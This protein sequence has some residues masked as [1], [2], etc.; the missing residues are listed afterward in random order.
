M[1]YV[2]DLINKINNM[3]TALEG[4]SW[5]Q[6]KETLFL[7]YNALGTAIANYATPVW[8]TSASD[9]SFK[10][11][12]TTQNAALTTATGDHKIFSIDHLHQESNTLKVRDHSDMLSAQYLVNC[13]EE[14]HVCHGITTQE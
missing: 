14:A 11:I 9:S 13:Q 1:H 2:A 10:K 4:L 7:T 12:Q 3:L 8:S 6:D 5:G